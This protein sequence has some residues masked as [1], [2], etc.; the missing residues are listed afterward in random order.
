MLR[1]SKIGSGEMDYPDNLN[2]LAQLYESRLQTLEGALTAFPTNE[3]L[4]D[5]AA[6][7]TRDLRSSISNLK[8]NRVAQETYR[9]LSDLYGSAEQLL[10]RAA[11]M[12]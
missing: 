10:Q 11:R 7:L 8:D 1:E 3:E 12:I 9:R 5:Q 4:L 6:D 2:K